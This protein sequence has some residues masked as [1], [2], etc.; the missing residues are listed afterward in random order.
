MD[1]DS[2]RPEDRSGLVVFAPRTPLAPGDR[3]RIG[4]AY[5]G[6]FPD[7]VSRNGGGAREFVL[8]SGAVLTGFSDVG[9]GPLIGWLPDIGVEADRNAS[10]PRV[11]PDDWWRRPLPGALPMFDGWSDTRIRVTS[12]ATF[13]HNATGTCVSD[14]VAG[15]RRTTEWRSE[16]PVRAFNVAVG[17]W[18]VKRREGVA[19]YYDARHPFNVDEM[20]DALA[21]ARRWYGEWFGAYPYRELRLSEFPGLATYAQGPPTNITFSE[22]IGFLTRSEPKANAAFWITAHEAA[23]QWWPCI[24]MPGEGPGG[25]V[26]S[27]G[28]AHFSTILLTGQV[29][30][31][32]QRM[33]FCRQIEDR[34][35]NVRRR[36]A[37][38]PLH[39]V[40]GRLPGENR[41]I[42]D[43]GGFVLWMLSELMGSE[44][45]MAAHRDY[46]AR[47]RDATDHPLIEDYLGVL[48]EHAP[49]PLAFDAFA[50]QWVLG[51]V[52]PQFQVTDAVL[53]RAG[54][55]WE[56]RA[57]VKNAGTGTVSVDVAA[58]RGER[59]PRTRTK[60]N[61]WSDARATVQLGPGEEKPV[62]L[63][64]R[65]EPQRLV[66][67]PDVR[68]L[69]LERQKA[70]RAL[71]PASAPA[72]LAYQAQPPAR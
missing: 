66:V 14:T 51:T 50:S 41:I 22:N 55:G 61:A 39:K 4:Y 23:H 47:Y 60:D 29:R 31:L 5:R 34:Y 19:V 16:A 36:D 69:M 56:V 46:L 67:D 24:A 49:D 71:R 37:E 27:E 44:A 33:A 52:L 42:Y 26:L 18:Q 11:Y 38:R 48:R 2:I 63:R 59:F 54:D 17:R 21:A 12:P 1:G 53:A 40:D 9:L 30:G 7:G 72:S 3:V 64:C 58:T 15:G 28:M 65:F 35:A 57:R 20:L 8:P 45:S 70:E 68:V 62:T 25:D 43:R 13:Q 32:E 6:E 10:D